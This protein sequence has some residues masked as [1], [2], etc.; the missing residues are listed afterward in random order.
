MPTDPIP[1]PNTDHATERPGGVRGPWVLILT[2][3]IMLTVPLVTYAVWRASQVHLGEPEPLKWAEHESW[4][5]IH[6]QGTSLERGPMSSARNNQ[7]YFELA[8]PLTSEQEA[9]V[10]RCV[11]LARF[12]A[13]AFTAPATTAELRSIIEQHPDLFYPRY[14][15]SRATGDEAAMAE[16]IA[17][18]PRVLVIPVTDD[19]G[20][21]AQGRVI[22]DMEIAVVKVDDDVIDESLVLRYPRLTTDARGRAY[23]PLFAGKY[24]I[25]LALPSEG[26]LPTKIVEGYF[27]FP[28]QLGKL[29][30]WV[31]TP[32]PTT[33]R[34]AD[35]QRSG[36]SAG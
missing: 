26:V 19:Q 31:V 36:A 8:S 30:A 15:L 11:Q 4:R 20:R 28:G 23:L 14:L 17:R 6:I 22:G 35:A 12:D 2:L 25:T 5:P 3:G 24:R 27:T 10:W 16:A 9:A 7:Q 21:V 34:P 1:N 13:D 33:R 29:P 18:T 32:P